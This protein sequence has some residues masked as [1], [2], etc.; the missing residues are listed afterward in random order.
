[1]NTT[2]Y[3]LLL[4]FLNWF[5]TYAQSSIGLDFSHHIK[6]INWDAITIEKPL[7]I[8]HKAT[9]GRS[10]TDKKYVERKAIASDLKVPFGGYHFFNYKSTGIKQA[11]HFISTALLSKG[12]VLPV[13]DLELSQNMPKTES[14]LK[15][16]QDYILTIQ[17]HLK[18]TPII[19]CEEAFYN[20]YL[21]NKFPNV[22]FWI[23]NYKQKPIS[24]YVIWQ[25]SKTGKK[26]KMYGLDLNQLHPDYTLN[27]ILIN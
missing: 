10:F 5:N 18:V 14:W 7:F 6:T 15:E 21:K 20:A 19:Y 26:Y 2:C 13:L 12:D 23:A 8:I 3:T 27:D 22:K 4:I 11:M 24:N 16:V 17:K 1:M 9:E 25:Y